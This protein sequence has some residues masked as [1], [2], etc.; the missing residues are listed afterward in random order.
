[1]NDLPAVGGMG[2][3]GAPSTSLL[4][5]SATTWMPTPAFGRSRLLRRHGGEGSLACGRFH[6]YLLTEQASEFVDASKAPGEDR[7]NSDETLV[8][9]I[10]L[11]PAVD[12]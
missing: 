11:G 10:R 2:C 7:S 5:L 4:L 6:S 3:A 9:A 1:M 12:Q 8:A